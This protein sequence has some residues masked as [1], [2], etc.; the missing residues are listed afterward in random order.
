MIQ[1]IYQKALKFAGEKHA[2][3][4]VP[5]SSANYLL[6]ISSVAMEV[7]IAHSEKP[8]FDL[9]LAVQAAILHDVIEDTDTDYEE[10]KEVFGERVALA[11]AALTKD[12][13]LSSKHEQM[14]D[15]LQRINQV[16]KEAGIVKLADRIT[17]LQHPPPHWSQAKASAYREEAKMIAEA[18][19]EKNEYL[20]QRLRTQIDKYCK[21]L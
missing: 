14:A 6:H 11:V 17:N 4:Q 1:E 13:H 16:E 12:T 21:F 10:V 5:G 7:L 20:H 15:S 18:L 19:G 2:H 3:Q 8:D 9:E